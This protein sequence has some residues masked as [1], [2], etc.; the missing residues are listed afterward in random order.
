MLSGSTVLPNYVEWAPL[1][2]Q[3]IE[4]DSN[5]LSQNSMPRHKMF[6]GDT[7]RYITFGV[8]VTK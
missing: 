8:T 2:E 6:P 1:T 4:T 5:K 7:G 3:I